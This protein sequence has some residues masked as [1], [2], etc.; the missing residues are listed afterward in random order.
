MLVFIHPVAV[1]GQAQRSGDV[2]VD[3]IT[4]LFAEAGIELRAMALELDDVPACR[5][6]RTITGGMPG[7]TRGEFVALHQQAIAPAQLRQVIK[8]AAACSTAADDYDP[9]TIGHSALNPVRPVRR[10]PPA[11]P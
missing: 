9:R 10:N 7:R 1:V 11:G 2:V 3:G 4:H 6:V 8:R 5:E